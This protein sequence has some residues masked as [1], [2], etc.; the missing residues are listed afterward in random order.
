[1]L[2]FGGSFIGLMLLPIDF[3]YW[4]FAVLIAANGVGTGMFGAPNSASIMNSVPASQRGAASGMRSTFLNS[5]TSLSIGVFFS[6]MIVGLSGTLPKTLSAGL[7]QQGV[8]HAVAQ[9]VATLP[10]VSSLFSAILGVNPIQNLLKPSGV[11]TTLPSSHQQVLTGRQ[12]FPQLISGP[13]HHGLIIVFA[14]SAAMSLFAAFASLLRGAPSVV[15][16]EVGGLST[17]TVTL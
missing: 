14:V 16:G 2:I 12:F 3:P 15:P 17:A 4:I 7:Q 5:G 9:H 11:L 6:L 8:S 1:M 13:F 10:P